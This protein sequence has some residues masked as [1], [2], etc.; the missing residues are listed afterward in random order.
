VNHHVGSGLF[1][2]KEEYAVS[3]TAD[4]QAASCMFSSGVK[5][6]E[7]SYS[8]LISVDT[9]KFFCATLRAFFQYV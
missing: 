6:W 4:W 7:D 8:A 1:E 9:K 3:V 5:K 2:A